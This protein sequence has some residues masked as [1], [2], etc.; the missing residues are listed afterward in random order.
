MTR[1]QLLLSL[2][3]SG[4]L[5]EG[6]ARR[7]GQRVGAPPSV[8]HAPTPVAVPVAVPRGR[9][10]LPVNMD[11]PSFSAQSAQ[12]L[13][14]LL[15]P[16]FRGFNESQDK[17][18]AIL[19]T[20]A[21]TP[22]GVPPGYLGVVQSSL[23]RAPRDLGPMLRS[24]NWNPEKLLPGLAG[25]L[26]AGGG[27]VRALP[28]TYYPLA[29]T[30]DVGALEH[31]GVSVPSDH[32]TASQFAATSRLVHLRLG[33][34]RASIGGLYP[35]EANPV[36]C[37]WVVGYGGALVDAAGRLVLTDRGAL[38][39]I[40]AWGA[41]QRSAGVGICP[42]AGA[43]LLFGDGGRTA[44]SPTLVAP[45]RG[46]WR[47]PIMP[48]RPVIP[49]IVAGL[50]I[51]QAYAHPGA[52]LS[53]LLWISSGPGQAAMV[54]AG[55]PT[56]LRAGPAGSTAWLRGLP[57]GYD[58]GGLTP[59]GADL[60][61]VPDALRRRLGIYLEGVMVQSARLQGAP[62]RRR[63]AAAERTANRALAASGTRL[64]SMYPKLDAFDF[65]KNG[66]RRCL[67]PP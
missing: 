38:A 39:G 41:V 21:T 43:V 6:C 37:G 57:P 62:L 40:A 22:H 53:F 49:T 20:G 52:A 63:L 31:A 3:L 28:Y 30:I 67:A 48:V 51:P 47:F 34:R 65:E 35:F 36:W 15:S 26:V 12:A 13:Q 19:H 1:R 11:A 32:W 50:A 45:Q 10:L 2:A 54:A 17:V 55:Y 25:A 66:Y 27:V 64:A 33:R 61:P 8:R 18:Y 60:F 29:V 23:T 14:G 16:V 24:A 56:I 5:L 42:T 9:V 46:V 7:T 59:P 58:R 4:A 44:A